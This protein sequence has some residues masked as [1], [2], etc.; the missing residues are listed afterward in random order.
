M[1]LEVKFEIYLGVADF[2]F[3]AS[4]TISE[5]FKTLGK[6]DSVVDASLLA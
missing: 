3:S 2:D 1:S 6:T 4:V 5:N